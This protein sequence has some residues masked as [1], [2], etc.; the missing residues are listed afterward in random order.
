MKKIK[1]QK[2]GLFFIASLVASTALFSQKAN[3]TPINI[4]LDQFVQ[5]D[6]AYRPP[7]FEYIGPNVP[8]PIELDI[9]GGPASFTPSAITFSS[10]IAFNPAVDVMYPPY[11]SYPADY[12]YGPSWL[13]SLE[14]FLRS[15]RKAHSD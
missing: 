11:L 12:I 6:S 15:F 3:A 4:P 14:L 13:L 1:L 10:T 7:Y 5:I 8:F 9:D 2:S